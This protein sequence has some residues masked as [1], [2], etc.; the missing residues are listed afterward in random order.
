MSDLAD[1][2]SEELGI[3]VSKSNVN[4]LFRDI[5]DLYVK[6]KGKHI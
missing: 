3:K 4:H 2:L 1:K 5:H 6:L